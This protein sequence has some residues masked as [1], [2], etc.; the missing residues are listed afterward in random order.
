MRG[1]R[2]CGCSRDPLGRMSW[3]MLRGS[4]RGL[5]WEGLGMGRWVGRGGVCLL[6]GR[7]L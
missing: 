6:M 3:L 7:R 2:L 1:L 4:F 5:R